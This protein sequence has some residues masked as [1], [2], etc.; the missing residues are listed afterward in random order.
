MY[1][2]TKSKILNLFIVFTMLIG[3]V[4][5]PTKTV[6][7]EETTYVVISEVY[8][9]GGNSG[10][11]LKN[12]FIELY[13]PTESDINLEGWKVQ[14]AAKTGMFNNDCE[15]IQWY[16][17]KKPYTRYQLAINRKYCPKGLQEVTERTDYPWVYSFGQQAVDDYK[18]LHTGSSV[19][20]DG[21]L[22]TRKYKETYKCKECGEE[23]DVPGR[24]IDVLSH[25]TE[26]LRDCDVDKIE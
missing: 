26:Y 16:V 4:T 22:R 15:P 2:L 13:N 25:D 20:V 6:S 8:G 3:F 17:E 9:G 7:A 21:T 24:T 23:F 12:D 5:V 14:Y 10:A 19:F 18:V 11:T 1:K